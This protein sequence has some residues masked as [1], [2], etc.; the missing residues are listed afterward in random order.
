MLPDRNLGDRKGS[1]PEWF[2]NKK[3]NILLEKILFF[4]IT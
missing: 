4:L 3:V 1:R 2:K